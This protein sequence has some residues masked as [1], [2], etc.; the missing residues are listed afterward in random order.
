MPRTKP[1]TI[2][3]PGILGY[4]FT[5]CL[6]DNSPG[7]PFYARLLRVE[8]DTTNPTPQQSLNPASSVTDSQNPFMTIRRVPHSTRAFSRRVGYHEPK[9]ATIT[10]P[11]ILGYRF[12]KSLYDN[13]PRTHY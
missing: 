1:A 11:G 6:Y 9:P 2:T 8:W 13:S 12:I 10:E 4:R 5:K 3:E 7:A